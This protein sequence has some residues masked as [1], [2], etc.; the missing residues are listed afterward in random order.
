MQ[1]CHRPVK[2]RTARNK[3]IT[4][5]KR[6][7]SLHASNLGRIF[8]RLHRFDAVAIQKFKSETNTRLASSKCELW[9]TC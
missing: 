8:R 6:E 3:K 4:R 1:V 7:L 5:V 9:I 2:T